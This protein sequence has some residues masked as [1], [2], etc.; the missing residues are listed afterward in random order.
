MR[1]QFTE[2]DVPTG[3]QICEAQLMSLVHKVKTTDVNMDNLAPYLPAIHEELQGLTY[4]ELIQHFVSVEFN[5]FLSHYSNIKDIS[6]LRGKSD[7][8][9]RGGRDRGGRDRRGRDRGRDRGGRR[10]RGGDI[11]FSTYVI[12]LGKND[13]FNPK[14]LFQMINKNQSLKGIEIGSISVGKSNTQFEADSRYDKKIIR[15]L[16]KEKFR[17][18][19]V[20]IASR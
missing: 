6:T 5:R 13:G 2:V 10:D 20:R 18:R 16:S 9:D 12:S 8:R 7:S 14:G 15:F 3:Q 4:D 17:G 1:K 19:P 11:R